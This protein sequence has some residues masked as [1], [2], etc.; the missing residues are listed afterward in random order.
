M[1]GRV[2]STRR[3]LDKI[4]KI[5]KIQILATAV[6]A[7]GHQRHRDAGTNLEEEKRGRA[8]NRR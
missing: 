2:V 3:I 1:V 5:D 7:Y 8:F 4:D 6:L